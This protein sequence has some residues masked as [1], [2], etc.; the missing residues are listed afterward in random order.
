MRRPGTARDRVRRNGVDATLLAALPDLCMTTP[1]QA[2]LDELDAASLLYVNADSVLQSVL[3]RV[4]AMGPGK[5]RLVVCDL[6]ASLYIDLAGSRML[7]QFHTELGS[8]GINLR[9]VGARGRVRDL[10]RAEGIDEKVGGS[11]GAKPS[12][13]F[14]KAPARMQ[15]GRHYPRGNHVEREDRRSR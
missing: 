13:S 2:K 7:H 15:P 1:P 4:R 12:T 6:S 9:I 5:I 14:W 11:T 8:H 3:D 10:L